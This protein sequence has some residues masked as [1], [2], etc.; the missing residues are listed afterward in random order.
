MMEDFLD[1]GFI[2]VADRAYFQAKRMDIFVENKQLFVIRLK[3]NVASSRKKALRRW[4]PVNPT[5]IGDF[6][7]QLSTPQKRFKLRH[8]VVEFTNMKCSSLQIFL[9][10]HNHL[11]I[12]TN[13]PVGG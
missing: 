9:K 10:Y 11:H 6:T 3:M 12:R 5:I 1:T 4:K 13:S 7:C 2:L 8:R